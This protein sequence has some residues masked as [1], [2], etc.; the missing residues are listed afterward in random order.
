MSIELNVLPWDSD[1]FGF[2]IGSADLDGATSDDLAQL[3][4]Q[5]RAAGVACVYGTLDPIDAPLTLEVQRQG[6]RFV[7]ASTMFSLRPDEPPIAKPPGMVFRRGTPDDLPHMEAVVAK[8]AAWSRYAVDPRFGPEAALRLQRAWIERAAACETDEF[9]L[10]VAEDRSDVVAFISRARHPDPVVDTVGTTARGSGAARY[11]IE[12]A[13]AW[14]GSG[15]V[16]LGGP[17]AA[18][19]VAALRYVSHCGY[20][21]QWVRYRYHRWLDEVVPR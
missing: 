8:L 11:L 14:A 13:R 16:L 9:S 15:Q 2:P 21:V 18:R 5:A 12:D 1:F 6:W 17:I 3:E 19:N 7:E 20:R 4:D 10:V